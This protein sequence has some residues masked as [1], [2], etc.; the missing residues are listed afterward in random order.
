MFCH[1]NWRSIV[2]FHAHPSLG[3]L[4]EAPGFASA[5]RLAGSDALDRAELARVVQR[6]SAPRASFDVFSGLVGPSRWPEL[7]RERVTAALGVIRGWVERQ[8]EQQREMQEIFK[9][10]SKP[11]EHEIEA[12]M[13]SVSPVAS[14]A[15]GSDRG[16]RR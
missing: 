11:G 6:Y 8:S 10:G 4:D 5:C 13:E 2:T 3:L 14:A 16:S 15:A 12:M 7:S 9:S 1:G